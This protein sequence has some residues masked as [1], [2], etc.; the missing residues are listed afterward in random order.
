M[1]LRLLAQ[2]LLAAQALVVRLAAVVPVLVSLPL[3]VEAELGL[4]AVAAQPRQPV[5]TGIGAPKRT[6]R[7]SMALQMAQQP[8]ALSHR[9]PKPRRRYLPQPCRL[10]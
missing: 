5:G 3:A 1:L 6:A 7:G 10:P 2:V 4:V 9:R 8:R